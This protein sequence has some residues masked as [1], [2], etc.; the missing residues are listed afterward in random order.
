MGINKF[1][2]AEK[3]GEGLTKEQAA[4]ALDVDA[5]SKEFAKAFDNAAS[6]GLIATESTDK[7]DSAAVWTQTRKGKQKV[8][9][10]R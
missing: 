2:I 7:T 9:S 10:N 4:K 1:D 8:A 6:H 5:T 3:V